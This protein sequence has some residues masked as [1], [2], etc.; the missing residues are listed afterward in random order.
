M[1]CIT[2]LLESGAPRVSHNGGSWVEGGGVY[3]GYE[4]LMVLNTYG[5]RCGYVAINESHSLHK[6]N[7]YHGKVGEIEVH[8]GVTFFDEQMTESECNDKWIGFDCGHFNDAA[9]MESLRKH[10]PIEADKVD[11]YMTSMREGTIR[12]KEYVE[13]ECKSIIDQIK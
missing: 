5:H 12:T 1:G 6:E 11:K 9:D 4:Y 2:Q 13:T 8:G 7:D 10:D 3:E